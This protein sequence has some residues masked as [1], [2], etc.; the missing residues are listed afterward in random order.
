VSIHNIFLS[1]IWC[2]QVEPTQTL[3]R[4]LLVT[5]KGQ[6][7]AARQWIDKNLAPLFTEYLT[8]N[9]A[10]V[11]NKENPIPHRT[12]VIKQTSSSA[13]WLIKEST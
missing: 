5:T 4:I 12:D 8:R 9:S 1:N 6:I 11:P 13:G 10:Y 3:G 2:L 7:T